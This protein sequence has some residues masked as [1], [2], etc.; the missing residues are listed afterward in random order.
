MSTPDAPSSRPLPRKE[1]PNR[2][3]YTSGLCAGIIFGLGYLSALIASLFTG[4]VT[5]SGV[6]VTVVITGAAWAGI[7]GW[8]RQRVVYSWSALLLVL[9]AI[10][11]SQVLAD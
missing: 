5:L 2:H 6:A 11:L 7:V 4:E 9:G 1:D 10:A 8:R 3:I